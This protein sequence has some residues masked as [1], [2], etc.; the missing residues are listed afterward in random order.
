MNKERAEGLVTFYLY[1]YKLLQNG[2]RFSW[3]NKKVS[4]GTC[5]YNKKR[6][7]LAKWY[8]E[9][10]DEDEVTDTILHEV[11]HALA[12]Q[13]HGSAGHGHGRIWKSICVEIGARPERLH[14]G[15]LGRPKNHHKYVDTCCGVTYKRHRLRKNARYS[16]PK[17]G[18]TLYKGEGAKMADRATK[19]LLDE[20]FSS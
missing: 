17:C 18:V 19:E 8:V 1:K 6:I 12:Y 9:L 15:K 20:I 2:W 3:H 7:Y 16:C 10:N 4:L 14:T 13:R 11:A 5:S